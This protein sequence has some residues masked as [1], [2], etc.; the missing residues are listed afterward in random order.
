MLLVTI[1]VL[2]GIEFYGMM[3]VGGYRPAR[4]L[5]LIWLV[6]LAMNGWNEEMMRDV[7]GEIP[8]WIN[9]LTL[10]GWTP[11]QIPLSYVLAIGLIATITYALFQEERPADTW[12]STS[13]GAIY[14]GIILGQAVS[15]RFQPN[16]FWWLLFALLIT[17]ANDSAAYFVGVTMGK[18]KLWPRLSPKKSWEGTIGGW[19]GAALAAMLLTWLMPITIPTIY[20]GLVGLVAGMLALVGDLSISMLKRQ[21]GVKDSGWLFPGHGGI[22]DR[23]DSIL[24]VIPFVYM[25]VSTFSIR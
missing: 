18:H 2:S 8:G 20:A 14:L 12:F 7:R 25:V 6:A 16:G 3:E 9:T 21:V 22:L 19:I 23:L 15:L 13:M 24:F 5:G 10:N 11:P 17:W 4:W 1:A